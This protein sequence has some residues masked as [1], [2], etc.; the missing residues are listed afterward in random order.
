M[1]VPLLLVG[2]ERYMTKRARIM[3]H[4]ISTSFE[5]KETDIRIDYEEVKLLG[6]V[7]N[8]I[9]A[10]RIG[11][12]IKTIANEIKLGDKYLSAED[13]LKK[14]YIQGII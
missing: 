8:E 6:R 1:A 11:S 5:G 9:I 10:N 12:S 3:T 2:D 4:Q 13:A 14:G 7:C